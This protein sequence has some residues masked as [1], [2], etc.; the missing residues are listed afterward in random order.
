MQ[1][2]TKKKL[3]LVVKLFLSALGI[4][5]LIGIIAVATD[6]GEDENKDLQKTQVSFHIDSLKSILTELPFKMKIVVEDAIDT[7]DRV[8]AQNG[9]VRCLAF[10]KDNDVKELQFYTRIKKDDPYLELTAR[11]PVLF[12]YR[13]DT[14]IGNW[15][16]LKLQSLNFKTEKEFDT[17]YKSKYYTISYFPPIE[18]DADFVFIIRYYKNKPTE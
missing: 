13:L 6:N 12:A 16:R 4:F 1:T 3:N 7:L 15:V 14:T 9:T 11:K 10:S 5:F 17:T 8:I 2:K 18:D